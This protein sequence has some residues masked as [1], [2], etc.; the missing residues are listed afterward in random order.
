MYTDIHYTCVH[1]LTNR[2][3]YVHNVCIHIRSR[4]NIWL[5]EQQLVSPVLT[6]HF[7]SNFSCGFI[8]VPSGIESSATNLHSKSIGGVVAVASTRML[9][10]KHS[11]KST[12]SGVHMRHLHKLAS[13]FWTLQNHH[14]FDLRVWRHNSERKLG[15][16]GTPASHR[17]TDD[18]RHAQDCSPQAKISRPCSRVIFY[19]NFGSV[20][21]QCHRRKWCQ[22]RMCIA[23]HK[24]WHKHRCCCCWKSARAFQNVS[25]CAFLVSCRMDVSQAYGQAR[26]S[27]DREKCPNTA[28]QICARRCKHN[29]V[30]RSTPGTKVQMVNGLTGGSRVLLVYAVVGCCLKSLLSAKPQIV[31]LTKTSPTEPKSIA[32]NRKCTGYFLIIDWIDLSYASVKRA[33]W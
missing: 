23:N 29:Y 9:A 31:I 28:P 12:P 22:T 27:D 24:S 17:M 13:S 33:C 19:W 8:V 15:V 20:S 1:S 7:F 5:L 6:T 18:R 14:D 10:H 30:K 4:N 26:A 25:S 2:H 3:P 32:T 11:P 16:S 21:S